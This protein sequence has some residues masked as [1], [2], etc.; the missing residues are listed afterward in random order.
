MQELDPNIE[1]DLYV[2][3][4]HFHMGSLRLRAVGLSHPVLW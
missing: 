1:G 3:A 2:S 4:G